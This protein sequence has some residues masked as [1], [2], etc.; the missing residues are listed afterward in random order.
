MVFFFVYADCDFFSSSSLIFKD[1]STHM[2]WEQT[3][4]VSVEQR[5][6]DRY[7]E[8]RL[9]LS[10]CFFLFLFLLRLFSDSFTSLLD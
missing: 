7:P 8:P 1:I 6:L 5:S 4:L 2:D 3:M 9:V 10:H